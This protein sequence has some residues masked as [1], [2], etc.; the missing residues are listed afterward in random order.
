[1]R[2]AVG[3]EYKVLIGALCREEHKE[4]KSYILL[5]TANEPSPRLQTNNHCMVRTATSI[6][7][8]CG[9]KLGVP[10]SQVIDCPQ[11]IK[12]ALG[13]QD[14]IEPLLLVYGT[15]GSGHVAQG[16]ELRHEHVSLEDNGDED[17]ILGFQKA[18]LYYTHSE[19]EPPKVLAN[20]FR[21]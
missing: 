15:L 11:F 2:F 18:N 12:F 8:A 9:H 5:T 20:P 1:L 6:W 4:F 3:G 17:D 10:E 21:F 13:G 7:E 16:C 14:G 19:Y